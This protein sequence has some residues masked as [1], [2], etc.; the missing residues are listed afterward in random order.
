MNS[1]LRYQDLTDT[2]KAIICNGCGGKGGWIK[3]PAFI[4]EAD[5]NRHDFHYWQGGSSA[6]RRRADYGF[7][8]AMRKDAGKNPFLQGLAFTYFVAVR[9]CGSKYFQYRDAKKTRED[10]EAEIFSFIYSSRISS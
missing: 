10:L 8:K 2:E 4:F 9:L 5:C 7:Y 6:D 3:P 1:E